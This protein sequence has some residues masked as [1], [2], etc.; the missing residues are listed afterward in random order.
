MLFLTDDLVG[1]Y[2][3]EICFGIF[4]SKFEQLLILFLWK[5]VK[6]SLFYYILSIMSVKIASI[7]N[8]KKTNAKGH[9]T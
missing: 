6:F 7:L 9:I 8:N 4:S 5:L 3:F 2:I 1:V